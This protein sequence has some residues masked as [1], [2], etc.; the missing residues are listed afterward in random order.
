MTTKAELEN[1]AANIG[2]ALGTDVYYWKESGVHSFYPGVPHS[3]GRQSKLLGELTASKLHATGL[4]FLAGIWKGRA[5]FDQEREQHAADK[6][7]WADEKEEILN[8]VALLEQSI[9]ALKQQLGHAG[10]VAPQRF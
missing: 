3:S 10:P 5:C 9:E 4:T 1:L 8:R 2:Q 6:Q 7:A